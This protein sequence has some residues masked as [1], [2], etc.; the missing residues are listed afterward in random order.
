M[1]QTGAT[2]QAGG[3]HRCAIGSKGINGLIFP[4]RSDRFD[5]MVGV[6][7]IFPW[8]ASTASRTAE[9]LRTH[10]R[11]ICSIAIGNHLTVP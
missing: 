4:L 1:I 9:V 6:I 7:G 2:V 3:T 10:G 8:S 5:R 11:R